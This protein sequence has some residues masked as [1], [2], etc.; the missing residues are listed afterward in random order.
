MTPAGFRQRLLARI[1]PHA[2]LSDSEVDRLEAYYSLLCRWNRKIN[3]TALP[4]DP[5]GEHAL[6]RLFVE[7]LVAADYVPDVPIQWA[8]LGTGGGS[9]AVPLKV[10]RELAELTMVESRSRKA[11]FLREVVRVLGLSNTRV[12]THRFEAI[13]DGQ[14]APQSVD[15]VTVRAVRLGSSFFQ[16]AERILAP[17]GRLMLFGSEGT[18]SLPTPSRFRLEVEVA[19]PGGDDSRLRIY[20]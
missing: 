13:R 9:P 15:L 1:A 14:I 19:L 6:D 10:S 5:L 7:P 16:L 18:D 20:G 17:G 2:S 12:L 3:L 8:D 11:A 4:L